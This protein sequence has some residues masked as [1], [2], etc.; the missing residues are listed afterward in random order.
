MRVSSVSVGVY[1]EIT[2]TGY[3]VSVTGTIGA[4]VRVVGGGVDRQDRQGPDRA[5]PH[6]RPRIA[7]SGGVAE[8]SEHR[9]GDDVP[10]PVQDAKHHVTALLNWRDRSGE[11]MFASTRSIRFAWPQRGIQ[12]Q[13]GQADDTDPFTAGVR[14]QGMA[15]VTAGVNDHDGPVCCRDPVRGACGCGNRRARRDR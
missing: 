5:P 4:E 13:V 15:A 14:D 3:P 2:P 11:L 6:P 9:F 10:Q 7:D 12:A 1:E 8:G